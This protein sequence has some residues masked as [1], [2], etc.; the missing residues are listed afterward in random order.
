M[1]VVAGA[2][3][4]VRNL[5]LVA[6]GSALVVVIFVFRDGHPD[7]AGWL[8][9]LFVVALVSWPAV[10][11]LMLSVALR[12]LAELPARVRATPAE[13]RERAVELR[14]LAER[15]QAV[16]GARLGALPFLLYRFGRVAA[17]SRE[18]L[19]PHAGALPL[20]S[21]PFLGLSAAA[22]V[23]TFVLVPI[24]LLLLILLASA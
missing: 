23:A 1:R 10:V 5:A 3:R 22:I 24:A 16:R 20:V 7:G 14:A 11:L 17:R 6:A 8:G 4:G 19:G 21:V 12:S 9:A 18:L 13:A 15:V 2:G